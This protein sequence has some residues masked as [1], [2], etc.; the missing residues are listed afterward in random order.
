MKKNILLNILAIITVIAIFYVIIYSSVSDTVKGN[1][2]TNESA[3][4]A[5]SGYWEGD[6]RGDWYVFSDGSYAKSEYIN[7]YWLDSAGWYDS[8]WDAYWDHN[9]TGWWYQSTKSKW[10]AK[11]TWLKIDGSWYYFKDSGYM[12]AN[13]WVGNYYLTGSGAMATNTWIGEYY[14]GSDGAWIPGYKEDTSSNSSNNSSSNSS[15]NNSSSGNNSSNSSNS[16]NSSS[17]N[18]SSNNNSSNNSS[19]NNGG[20]GQNTTSSC[21]H[22]WVTTTTYKVFDPH[23]S[24]EFKAVPVDGYEGSSP[25]ATHGWY[26][27]NYI[28][29]NYCGTKY[30]SYSEFRQKDT[31]CIV[32]FTDKDQCYTLKNDKWVLITSYDYY[33]NDPTYGSVGCTEN[34]YKAHCVCN[35]GQRF[36]TGLEMGEHR[37]TN[38]HTGSTAL[39]D[40]ST[41]TNLS[42]TKTH[43]PELISQTTTTKCSKC[44]ESK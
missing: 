2:E 26:N 19:S 7:G 41:S 36:E 23:F 18:N 38:N 14:V 31:C 24:N 42:Y 5:K 25:N 6:S 39:D 27:Y 11:N 43:Y 29:C 35:C 17:N 3:F 15:S 30:S 33:F 1:L 12:A 8:T 21:N 40:G 28:V 20:T 4:S 16:G 37:K 22:D 32:T 44:G 13:E 9:D 34:Q 10:Y